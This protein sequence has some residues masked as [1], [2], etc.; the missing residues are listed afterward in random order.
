LKNSIEKN[1][2]VVVSGNAGVGK[3][4]LIQK[5]LRSHKEKGIWLTYERLHNFLSGKEKSL[6][7]SHYIVIHSCKYADTIMNISELFKLFKNVKGWFILTNL[8]EKSLFPDTSYEIFNLLPFTEEESNFY[9]CKKGGF[10]KYIKD[11][12]LRKYLKFLALQ[13]SHHP[14][15]I[16]ILSQYFKSKKLKSTNAAP[17]VKKIL[18]SIMS[19]NLRSLT[20]DEQAL[21]IT[22]IILGELNEKFNG[23][24]SFILS[25]IIYSPHFQ[26]DQQT[27]ESTLKAIDIYLGRQSDPA[28][29][30]QTLRHS[31]LIQDPLI[32]DKN[33]I[34]SIET[35]TT[36]ILRLLF[37]GS[38]KNASLFTFCQKIR[39]LIE[40]NNFQ[41]TKNF[42]LSSLFLF[43]DYQSGNTQYLKAI[44]SH[45][46]L[47]PTILRIEAEEDSLYEMETDLEICKLSM[48]EAINIDLLDRLITEDLLKP[49]QQSIF[50]HYNLN[51][52]NPDAHTARRNY[53]EKDLQ[54]KGYTIKKNVLGDGNCQFRA[55]SDQL[56]LEDD[57]F[58]TMFRRKTV[59]WLRENK[60]LKIGESDELHHFNYEFEEWDDFCDYMNENGI[61]GDHITL[62][63]LAN[64]F[65]LR[66]KVI[67]ETADPVIVLPESKKFNQKIFL[68]HHVSGRHYMS[69]L[70]LNEEDELKRDEEIK[71][72]EE[73]RKL[74]EEEEKKIREEKNKLEEEKKKLQQEEK[75][76]MS[77]EEKKEMMSEEEKKEEEEDVTE[78]ETLQDSKKRKLENNDSDKENE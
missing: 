29:I 31:G 54:K 77:E 32:G 26:W 41:I 44:Y 69:I 38:S 71:K 11:D 62:I 30:L 20:F 17:E 78:E 76:E 4:F 59:Q 66:I 50:I 49:N 43:F 47:E 21:C 60:N 2:L 40:E 7:E 28:M 18:Q 72:K 45:G 15:S 10:E 8:N 37:N 63:A 16:Q 52:E 12:E 23:I 57:K 51:K 61:W 35:T 56:Q 70:P 24:P 46:Q 13:V 14:W 27:Y 6:I 39:H 34:F 1:H 36:R 64:Q 55:V 42:G 53:I 58:H 75:K 9:L 73:E 19:S 3:K 74:K 5:F 67:S 22:K 68:Y 48:E 25:M 33:T 65:S